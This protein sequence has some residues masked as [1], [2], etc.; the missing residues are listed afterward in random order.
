[1][2]KT[3]MKSAA[4]IMHQPPSGVAS[5]L[6]LNDYSIISEPELAAIKGS[7]FAGYK[8]PTFTVNTG[9]LPALK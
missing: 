2:M 1:M 9:S 7:C 5:R 6:N 3:S 8:V 4:N